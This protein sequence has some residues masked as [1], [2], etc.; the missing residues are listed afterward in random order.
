MA[1]QD[2]LTSLEKFS[3]LPPRVKISELRDERGYN[4]VFAKK[5][6][7][8]HGLAVVIHF[9]KDGVKVSTFLPKRF[10]DTLTDDDITEI[11]TSKSFKFYCVG[12]SGRSPDIKIWKE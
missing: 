3:E 1:L 7:T 12:M 2:K 9:M 10:V 8:Q 4:I 5:I 11:D 6:N